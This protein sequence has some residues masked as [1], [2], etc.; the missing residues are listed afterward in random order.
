MK[1]EIKFESLEEAICA[2]GAKILSQSTTLNKP[3]STSST[4]VSQGLS[5][6][7]KD[8]RAELHSGF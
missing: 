5:G 6:N 2:M 1:T 8:T 3:S 7:E 4:A